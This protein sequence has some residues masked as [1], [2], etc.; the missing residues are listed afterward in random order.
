MKCW[1]FKLHE[2]VDQKPAFVC[3]SEGH[4]PITEADLHLDH[5]LEH[6]FFS[7][8]YMQLKLRVLVLADAAVRARV[9]P[10]EAGADQETH[11][12]LQVGLQ[13]SGAPRR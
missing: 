5:V 4:Q 10:A 1:E 7:H 6:V 13:H 8:V 9:Q 3:A 2:C 11:D 12:Q